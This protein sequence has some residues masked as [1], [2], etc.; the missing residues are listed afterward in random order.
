MWRHKP[1]V[2]SCN[3]L[4]TFAT[5]SASSTWYR[6]NTFFSLS[7]PVLVYSICF[8]MSYYGPNADITG[9]VGIEIWSYKAV[10]DGRKTLLILFG[11]FVIDL[12]SVLLNA[13]II[14][15]HCKINIFQELSSIFHKYWYIISTH[16]ILRACIYFISNDI[17]L[18]LDWTFEF[19]WIESKRPDVNCNWTTNHNPNITD[20][21]N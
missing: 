3:S 5:L 20:L 6:A 4:N 21:S 18:G 14:W 13:K 10:E 7:F 17:N 2:D 16:L 12:F 19:C 15:I 9:N 11:L 1:S 8:A